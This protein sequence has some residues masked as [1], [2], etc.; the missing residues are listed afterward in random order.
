[1]RGPL[2]I[3]SGPSGSGKSTVLDRLLRRTD[4]PLHLAVS[5]TTRPSRPGEE[6]GVA[7]HFWTAE[8]FA[9]ELA[10]GAFLEHESVFGRCEY[11][12]LRSEV[13][14]H[15]ERGEGVI[16]EIDV[17]GAATVRQKCPDNVSVFLQTP[18]L[19]DYEQ[20][21]RKR[22]TESDEEIQRR[23]ARARVELERAEEYDVVIIND[24][25]DRAANELEAII[26]RQ[27]EGKE[28]AR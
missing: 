13:E 18:S 23:L 10:A 4:L 1:M 2:I 27:F 21:L 15:R 16:L 26:R 7:Y 12:T 24:D 8:R 6:D 17:R 5:A 9:E 25:V 22:G 20:R 11:G 14:P 19:E 3:L 28:H